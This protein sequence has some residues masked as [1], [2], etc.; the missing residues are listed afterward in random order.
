MFLGDSLAIQW[1]GLCAS[2]PGP[3]F[4]FFFQG[5]VLIPGQGTKILQAVQCSKK[6]KKT[7]MNLLRKHTDS[8]IENKLMAPK[9][10]KGVGKE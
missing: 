8:D 9:W 2:L 4:L 5:L 3:G 10:E 7:Q 1:L 6:K